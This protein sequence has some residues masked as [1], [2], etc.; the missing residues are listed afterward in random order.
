MPNQEEPPTVK[1]MNGPWDERIALTAVV[2]PF[3]LIL[4]AAAILGVLIATGVVITDV[5]VTG[6]I[7]VEQLYNQILYPA[8]IVFGSLVALT[9]LMSLMKIFGL[10]PVSWVIRSIAN[11]ADSYQRDR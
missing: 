4:F 8:T 3:V 11:I 5:T 1:D 2:T 9:W 6:S 7:P 10:A